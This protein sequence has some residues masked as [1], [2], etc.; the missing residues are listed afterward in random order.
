MM[1]FKEM[2][3]LL[4]EMIFMLDNSKMVLNMDM[5]QCKVA[6]NLKAFGTITIQLFQVNKLGQNN[7]KLK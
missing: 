4:L 1:L 7:N 2:V 3:N 6:L 5:A